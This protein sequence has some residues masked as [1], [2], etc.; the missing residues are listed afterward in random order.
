[1]NP[2]NPKTVINFSI[3]KAGTVV[4]SVYDMLGRKIKTLLNDDLYVGR[5]TLSW[6][7]K[8]DNGKIVSSGLY[9]YRLDAGNTSLT[10]KMLLIK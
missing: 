2:F 5:H 6:D 3:P 8:N 10:K 7:G 9:L 4:I 1:P